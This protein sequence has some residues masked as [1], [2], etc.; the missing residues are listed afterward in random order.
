MRH[1]MSTVAIVQAAKKKSEDK[2]AEAPKT[3]PTAVTKLKLKMEV[4]TSTTTAAPP[5]PAEPAVVEPP[6]PKATIVPTPPE[7]AIPL[8]MIEDPEELEE[9]E[10]SGLI[11]E[12]MPEEPRD[13]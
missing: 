13:N 3:L 5:P 8:V 10:D 4:P 2:K 9:P 12:V 6:A 11:D 7:P 1:P